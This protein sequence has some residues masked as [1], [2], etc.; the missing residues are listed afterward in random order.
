MSNTLHKRLG[1]EIIHLIDNFQDIII[2]KENHI[3]DDNKNITIQ[4]NFTNNLYIK[5]ILNND[6]PFKVPT[7]YINQYLYKKYIHIFKKNIN[8]LLYILNIACPCCTTI[9]EQYNWCP[10]QTIH[11]IINEYIKNFKLFNN[12]YKLNYIKQ[13]FIKKYP[14]KEFNTILSNI[15][16]YLE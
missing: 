4:Y 13:Y 6:Y 16:Y 9:T 12:L 1:Y 3:I 10:S 14:Y 11:N 15:Y 8:E 5:I 7:I 2:N